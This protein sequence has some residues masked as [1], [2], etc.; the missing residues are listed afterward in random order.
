MEQREGRHREPNPE[1]PLEQA[2]LLLRV[3]DEQVLGLLVVAEHH[4]VG[5]AAEAGL[6]VAAER[7]VGGGISWWCKKKNG[8][9]LSVRST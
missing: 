3:G 7:G 6:L 2:S 8:L 9:A 1:H 4:E 5:L